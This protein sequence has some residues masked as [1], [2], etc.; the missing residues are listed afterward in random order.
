MLKVTALSKKGNIKSHEETSKHMWL[1]MQISTNLL[2]LEQ[3][4]AALI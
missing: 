1:S 2:S 3:Y 4:F